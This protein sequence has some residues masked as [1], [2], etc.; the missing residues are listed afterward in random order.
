MDFL[1]LCISLIYHTNSPHKQFITVVGLRVF[2][3]FLQDD[4]LI[5]TTFLDFWLYLKAIVTKTAIIVVHFYILQTET[6]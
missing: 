4:N 2:E 5:Y 3:Y 6:M 1:T